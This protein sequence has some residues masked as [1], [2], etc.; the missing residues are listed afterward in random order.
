MGPTRSVI[1]TTR[2]SNQSSTAPLKPGIGFWNMLA[3]QVKFPLRSNADRRDTMSPSP[4]AG[5]DL[6][7]ASG[8]ASGKNI[9]NGNAEGKRK[10]RKRGKLFTMKASRY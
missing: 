6:K 1:E 10:V 2:H 5:D 3:S 8:E 7:K 4:V 9:Q